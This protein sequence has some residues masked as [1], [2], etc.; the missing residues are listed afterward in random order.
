MEGE[1]NYTVE[2]DYL[3]ATISTIGAELISLKSK[4]NIE[5]IWQRDPHHWDRCA[6]VLFPIVGS[7]KNKKTIIENQVYN[8]SAHGFLRDQEFEVLH[9][10]NNEISFVNTYNKETLKLYPYKY[11][12]IITFSL[13]GKTLRTNFK[14]VNENEK[15][16][17]FNIGGHPAFNCPLYP[18]EGFNDYTIYFSEPESFISPKVENNGTL[19]FDEIGRR[20]SNLKELRLERSLFE[21]DT[22]VIPRIKS[23]VVN[24]FNNENKGIIFRFPKFISFA[25][26]SPYVTDAP[27]VCLEPW[28]GYGDRY[29]TNHQ[30]LEKDNVITLKSLEEYNVYYDIEI[31]E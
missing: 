20:Y 12:S 18:N 5:Y 27:F 13:F 7:L 31:V 1:M 24:L 9:E 17:P 10:S 15:D 29:D 14:I 25:I 19:N 4:N 2:N 8:M 6:P 3:L 26:W 28:V 22:I 11:K 30:F 16:L 23:K 21:I